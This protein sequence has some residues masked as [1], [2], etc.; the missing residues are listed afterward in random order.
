MYLD[1]HPGNIICYGPKY[2]NKLKE[3]A[4]PSH[5]ILETFKNAV[6]V[7]TDTVS[8]GSKIF[9]E[10]GI[11][12]C[13]ID[14]GL[15]INLNTHDQKNLVALFNAVVHN[16]GELVGRLLIRESRS[17]D[18]VRDEDGFKRGIASVVK[19]IHASGLTLG[20]IGVSEILNEVLSLC[21]KHQVKIESRY[22][23]VIVAMGVVEGIGRQ[24]DP[25]VDIL[26][27]AAP[28]I[29]RAASRKL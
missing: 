10:S 6:G 9:S 16:D 21:Y 17:P 26:R 8:V 5:T 4:A 29:F 7:V 25:D 11:S 2:Y 28:Y 23:T 18:T 19:T 20:R 27:Q 24:L 12:M 15:A 3:P 22:A 14:A 13:F 1:L